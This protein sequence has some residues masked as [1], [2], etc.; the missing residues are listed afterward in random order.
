MLTRG[1]AALHR[2]DW[3]LV[4]RLYAEDVDYRIEGGSE[5]G[6]P[7]IGFASESTGFDP[8]QEMF[9]ELYSSVDADFRVIELLDAGDWFAAVTV[10][11]ARG[12]T[13]GLEVSQRQLHIYRTRGGLVSRQQTYFSWS[14]GLEAIGLDHIADELEREGKVGASPGPR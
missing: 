13:S 11:D 5:S 8:I 9:E 2:K 1:F 7:I 14:A 12:A 3:D 10:I 6:L 4:R